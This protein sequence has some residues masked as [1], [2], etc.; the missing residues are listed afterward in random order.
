LIRIYLKD[1][2]SFGVPQ[3]DSHYLKTH[4]Y[5]VLQGVVV[6]LRYPEGTIVL[7]ITLSTPFFSSSFLSPCNKSFIQ[8]YLAV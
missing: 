5:T 6:I 7:Q 2:S 1:N 3:D 8:H 4:I